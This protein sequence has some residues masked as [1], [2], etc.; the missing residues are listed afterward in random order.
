[1]DEIFNNY[2]N[3]QSIELPVPKIN[4]VLCIFPI[5]I[6]LVEVGPVLS[7][8]KV[9]FQKVEHLFIV[10]DGC[11]AEYSSLLFVHVEKWVTKVTHQLEKS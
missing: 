9:A 5:N 8:R 11:I 7:K 3:I 10:D 1:M 4:V 6:L 2:Y